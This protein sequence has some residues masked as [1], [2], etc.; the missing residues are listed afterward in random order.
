MEVFPVRV[1]SCFRPLYQRF[2]RH[3]LS[4]YC[5][6]AAFVLHG[7]VKIG[8][9]VLTDLGHGALRTEYYPGP[10][11]RPLDPTWPMT[12]CRPISATP[13]PMIAISWSGPPEWIPRG[14][15]HADRHGEG[16]GGVCA[17]RTH[18]TAGGE[19]RPISDGGLPFNWPAHFCATHNRNPER[20][21]GGAEPLSR[22]LHTRAMHFFN[23]LQAV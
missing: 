22:P 2:E 9:S 17:N 11:P 12:A 18:P 10:S 13:S 14:A 16:V 19:Q 4:P 20:S 21:G 3:T 5:L 8:R 6:S 1:L 7:R 23:A 15:R